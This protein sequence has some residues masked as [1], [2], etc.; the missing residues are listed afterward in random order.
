[1]ASYKNLT[2]HSS[3]CL[4][5]IF[6]I[7]FCATIADFDVMQSELVH[8]MVRTAATACSFGIAV[9]AIIGYF[10]RNSWIF[11]LTGLGFAAV[12]FF[13]ISSAVEMGF[14]NMGSTSNAMQEHLRWNWFFK[15]LFLSFFLAIAGHFWI[16]TTKHIQ[17]D[18]HFAARITGISLAVVIAIQ[19]I[20]SFFPLG[21]LVFEQAWL[22]RPFELLPAALYA[23]ALFGFLNRGYKSAVRIEFWFATA[24]VLNLVSHAGFAVFSSDV[25]DRTSSAALLLN[26]FASISFLCGL[27]DA[28]YLLFKREGNILNEL[29]RLQDS[30]NQHAI[31]STTDVRGNIIS[32]NDA[33]CEISGY[34]REELLGQNHSLLKSDEYDTRFYRDMWRQIASGKIWNGVF[35]NIKKNG[36][37][38]WVQATIVPY[39]NEDGKPF[40]YAAI[41]T[42]ITSTKRMT[43]AVIQ[44]RELLTAT[45]E[46]LSQG[47][48]VFDK[49]LKLIVANKRFG[50]I[51]EL[52]SDLTEVGTN[53][54][55]I[56]RYNA[57]RGEYGAGD[58]EELVAERIVLAQNPVA[59]RFDRELANGKTVQIVGSPMPGG[60][61]V[62]TYSDISERKKLEQDLIES[63]NKAETANKA[64]S[65]F[66]ATMSHEIRTPLNGVLGMAQLLRDEE[67]GAD[68]RTKVDNILMSGEAL[69]EIL[70]DV[71]D[72]SKIESGNVQ[73]EEK[74]FDLVPLLENVCAPFKSLSEDRGIEFEMQNIASDHSWYAGDPTRIRQV[75]QNLLSNAFKFTD[76]GSIQVKAIARKMDIL[77]DDAERLIEIS[78]A[79]TG[80]GISKGRLSN[81]FDVFVQ[82]DNTITRK[83]GGSGLGLAIVKNLAQLMGG[84]ISVKSEVNVGSTFTFSIT[85]KQTQMPEADENSGEIVH[86]GL[87][88]RPLKIL[89]AEDNNLNA[90][91]AKSM[92]EQQGH[93]VDFAVN[94]LEAVKYLKNK[95]PDL[96]LMDVHMPEMSGIEATEIIRKDYSLK[97]LPIIGVTAESFSDRLAELDRVGMNSVLTKPFTKQ[98]LLEILARN[99]GTDKDQKTA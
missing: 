86:K 95:M 20:C 28:N 65:N 62:T 21:S 54:S 80:T 5:A 30:I 59:H 72:M 74:P 60:G 29:A 7:A 81:I 67:L 1:M 31:V 3:Y 68:Q 91:I 52:P 90:L 77:E 99:I 8:S 85:L 88:I 12:V 15:N 63:K 23:A 93:T 39:L 51:L 97:E 61:F 13:G 98:Q 76:T 36:E 35:K 45:K 96:I 4:P 16:K 75:V 18:I 84:D 79:D 56:I 27:I 9:L 73:I 55:D 22:Q 14:S 69:L 70:N 19:I 57:M 71:L 89:V 87:D 50:E 48:S 66:L 24:L 25:F 43:D 6:V 44:E 64:K 26:M 42:D 17:I 37:P 82:E 41:R 2:K 10:Y 33:F 83:F 92:L 34:S 58:I 47:L 46:N 32:C 11:L 78:V 49:D 53:Y 38:Y 40:Q 94:G